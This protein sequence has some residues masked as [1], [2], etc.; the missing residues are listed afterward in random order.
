MPHN[1]GHNQGK[2]NKANRGRHNQQPISQTPPTAPSGGGQSLLQHIQSALPTFHSK[3]ALNDSFFESIGGGYY[4]MYKEATLRFHNW[5]ANQ[6]CRGMKMTAVNDYRRGVDQIVEYN[7]KLY[8]KKVENR[9][10][11]VAPPDIMESLVSSIRLRERVAANLFGSKTGGD[12]GHQY[13]A[14]CCTIVQ[15]LRMPPR[16]ASI[17]LK[18]RWR[19]TI[20]IFRRFTMFLH[21]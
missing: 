7:V 11:I 16:N 3:T 21:S 15:L 6:A 12:Q 17:E 14:T 20:L 8:L 13:I 2:K 4:A 18:T 5:M 9:E 10:F 1:K 19:L